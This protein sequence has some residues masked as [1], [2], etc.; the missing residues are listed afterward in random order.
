MRSDF[1]ENEE[2]EYG[3]GGVVGLAGSLYG[4]SVLSMVEDFQNTGEYYAPWTGPINR[5]MGKGKG[6]FNVSMMNRSGGIKARAIGPVTR[7]QAARE[8]IKQLF[9]GSKFVGA[10]ETAAAR[11]A[12]YAQLS[13]SRAVGAVFSGVA[14]TDPVYYGFRWLAKPTIM[15]LG[16][17]LAWF[18]GTAAIQSTARALRRGQYVSMGGYFPDSQSA[19]TSR[20]RAVRAIS[21]SNL[22][23]RSAI[24]N[25][26]MLFHR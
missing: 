1:L 2:Q 12:G 24:G 10:G 6:P 16:F 7:Q 17:G 8:E 23:A 26:A 15:G 11:R 4:W 21:E 20:Q 25:E 18:G 3:K 14:L 13:A 9:F 19:F 5:A 22:Q